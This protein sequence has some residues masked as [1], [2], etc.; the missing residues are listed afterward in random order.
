M[1]LSRVVRLALLTAVVALVAGMACRRPIV[2]QPDFAL[3]LS[4]SGHFRFKPV[5]SPDGHLVHY[6][7][8]SIWSSDAWFLRPFRGGLRVFSLEDSSDRSIP[9]TRT[10]SCIL[11]GD[12]N[13]NLNGSGET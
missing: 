5:V 9:R 4:D 2:I 1:T 8:D 7:D 11:S 13:L 3:L 12:P 10:T 6:L